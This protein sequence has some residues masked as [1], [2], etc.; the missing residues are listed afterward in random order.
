MKTSLNRVAQAPG[1]YGITR[2]VERLLTVLKLIGNYV[3]VCSAWLIYERERTNHTYPISDSTRVSLRALVSVVTG[4]SPAEVE[5]LFQ[6]LETDEEFWRSVQRA[7]ASHRLAVV[8]GKVPI[9]QRLGRRLAWYAMVRVMKPGLVVETGTDRGLGTAILARAVERN[10]AGE[11][12]TVDIQTFQ[13]GV[14]VPD[15]LSGFVRFENSDSRKV[16]AGLSEIDLFIHDSNH[17][18]DFE[19]EEFILALAS[20]SRSGVLL[21]DNAEMTDVLAEISEEHDRRFL[22]VLEHPKRHWHQG[23]GL[24]VSWVEER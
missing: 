22:S 5:R 3:L 18:R 17:D 13:R 11:I 12:V 23:G 10:S 2:F 8:K 14:L 16:I 7:G 1:L 21:T 20:L 19:H 9:E 4:V 15:S 6:E 24:G